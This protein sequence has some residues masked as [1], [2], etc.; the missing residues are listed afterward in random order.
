V[1]RAILDAYYDPQFST[2]SHGFRPGRGCHTAL[3]S[4]QHGWRGTKWSIEGDIA[5]CFD[6]L[7]H[8]ILV[9]ILREKIHDNRFLKL[10]ERM[11]QAGYLEDWSWHGTLS[12]TPQGNIASPILSNCY[13]DRLDRFVETTLLPKYNRGE[14]RR[15]NAAHTR[16]REMAQRRRKRGAHEEARALIHQSRRLP[17]VDPNDPD[18][19]RLRYLR[20]A[21]DFLLGFDGPKHE[22]EEI[23]H[24]LDTF[25]RDTLK[26]ELSAEK[27]LITH[28][29]TQR[30]RFLGY[31]IATRWANHHLDTTGRRSLNGSIALR[32]PPD[33]LER[34]CRDHCKKG[35]PTHRGEFLHDSDYAVV[36]MHQAR[37]RGLVQYYLLAEN[38]AWLHRLY[39]IMLTSLLK[40]LA[41]K[42]KTTTT[43]MW[44]KYAATVE[45]EHGPLR[46][47]QVVVPRGAKNPW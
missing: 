2:H 16:L 4:I 14:C 1:I 19:R 47:V 6:R 43:K 34:H 42:H 35:K 27:T 36:A 5:A 40:T 11:L 45:T 25:L 8:G 46:C 28:A 13:L 10:I 38:I 7:D 23:K 9:G 24:Q 44:R 39:W 31:E 26:L 21:D 33:V 41:A 29:R 15:R 17:S 12:G 37:Y 22:A 18:F 32:I 20:Y 3:Q 30:A